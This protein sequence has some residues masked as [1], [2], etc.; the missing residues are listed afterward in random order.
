MLVL[1]FFPEEP[2]Q[3]AK[4]CDSTSYDPACLSSP[5]VDPT[6]ENKI[7]VEEM[8]D[9]REEADDHDEDAKKAHVNQF[10]F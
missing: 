8:K 7:H 3:E 10:L 5:L 6:E 4:K 9:D 2:E 1:L